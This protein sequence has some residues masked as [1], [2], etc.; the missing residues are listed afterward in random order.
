[1]NFRIHKSEMEIDESSFIGLD[2]LLTNNIL[3]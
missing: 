3:A 2:F 1:M